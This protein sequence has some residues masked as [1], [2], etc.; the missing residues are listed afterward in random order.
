MDSVTDAIQRATAAFANEICFRFN[1]QSEDGNSP[2]R[3]PEEVWLAFE[4]LAGTY[5]KARTKKQSCPDFD[6]SIRAAISGWSYSGHQNE[7]T[8]KANKAWY[9][10]TAFD[11][12]KV[13]IPEHLRSGNGRDAEEA[14]RIAFTWDEQSQKVIIGFLGQHQRNT[15]SN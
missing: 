8:M 15:H 6:A 1:Q 14:I 11:G 3:Y 9:Q 2:Y 10:C 12:R 7:S 13:W 4:W 5:F